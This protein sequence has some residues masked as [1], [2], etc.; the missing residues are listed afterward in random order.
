MTGQTVFAAP[1]DQKLTAL[2]ILFS[3]ITLGAAALLVWIGLTRVQT[4]P[5]RAFLVANAIIPVGVF[6]G[7]ALMGPRSYAIGER[8]LRIERWV[9]TIQIPFES[10]RVV[11]RLNNDQLARSTRTFGTGGFFGWYGQFRNN[12]MGDYRMYA[13]RGDGY[14][15]IHAERPYVLTPESPDGF[16]EALNRARGS[17]A[18]GSSRAPGG[19]EGR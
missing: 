8:G 19:R 2:T 14:V 3:A 16:I 10:I 5:L 6:V 11:E 15:V 9:K 12:T 7:A 1:W 18:G 13:T 4:A 17:A